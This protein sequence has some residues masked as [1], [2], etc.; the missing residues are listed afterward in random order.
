MLDKDVLCSKN[1]IATIS[2]IEG[3]K[4]A[5]ISK[6]KVKNILNNIC[7]LFYNRKHDLLTFLTDFKEEKNR[8]K[9]EKKPSNGGIELQPTVPQR[10]SVPLRQLLAHVKVKKFIVRNLLN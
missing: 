3:R 4:T 6:N 7:E 8:K 1:N 2:K 9:I 5:E 10:L